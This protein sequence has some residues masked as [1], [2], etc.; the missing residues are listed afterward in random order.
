MSV[1]AEKMFWDNAN[2]NKNMSHRQAKPKGRGILR[3]MR[4]DIILKKLKEL[5]VEI[6]ERTLQR[7]VKE[8][9]VPMPERKSG[10]RG[11]GKITDYPESTVAEAYASYCLMHGDIK[12]PPKMVAVARNYALYFEDNPYTFRQESGDHVSWAMPLFL[13]DWLLDKGKAESGNTDRDVEITFIRFDDKN[14]PKWEKRINPAGKG[15]I[16]VENQGGTDS[17]QKGNI[18]YRILRMKDIDYNQVKPKFNDI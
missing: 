13:S 5:G 14:N 16:I 4:P 7:Y 6:S 1:A 18:E 3:I 2:Y 9:L 17:E 10:G 8:G 15:L 11:K 12:L